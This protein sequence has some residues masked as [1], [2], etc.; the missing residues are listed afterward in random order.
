VENCEKGSSSTCGSTAAIV[1]ADR[2]WARVAA[3]IALHAWIDAAGGLH[4]GIDAIIV[5]AAIDAI[6]SIESI[7]V[8]VVAVIGDCTRTRSRSRD[9][10]LHIFSAIKKMNTNQNPHH[11]N[12]NIPFFTFQ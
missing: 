9:C 8:V 5:L 12:P 10:L 6:K 11:K 2:R 4:T 7:V 3:I 1:I